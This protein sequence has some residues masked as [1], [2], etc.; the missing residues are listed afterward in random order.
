MDVYT[1]LEAE[2]E[3]AITFLLEIPPLLTAGITMPIFGA[4]LTPS[5]PLKRSG[6]PCTW[7]LFLTIYFLIIV[8]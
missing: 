3:V 2:P 7:L 1:T 8:V 6:A 5:L 4:F